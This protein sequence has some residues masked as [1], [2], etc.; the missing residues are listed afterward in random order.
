MVPCIRPAPPPKTK[1][2]VSKDSDGGRWLALTQRPP[3]AGTG[4]IDRVVTMYLTKEIAERLASDITSVF[5][6][7]E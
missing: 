1:W 7:E 3:Y 2:K 6:G 4:N 5:N